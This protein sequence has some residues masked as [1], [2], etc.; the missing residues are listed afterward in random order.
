MSNT[1]P[2]Q[3]PESNAGPHPPRRRFLKGALAAG[4]VLITLQSKPVLGGICQSPSGSMSGSLSQ[5]TTQVETCTGYACTYW[6]A[7][8]SETGGGAGWTGIRPDTTF[9]SVFR[10]G[11]ILS[12][13]QVELVGQLPRPATMYE[14]LCT[15]PDRDPSGLCGHFIAALL[16]INAGLIPSTVMDSARLFQ[17]WNEWALTGYYR[18]SAI[19]EPWNATALVQYFK[20]SGIA[21]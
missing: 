1:R 2:D 16:N 17:I 18:P 10:E 5:R 11:A 12:S 3:S 15:T 19:A 4:P 13:R 8:G 6:R 14:V 20:S 9:N 7:A 21:P